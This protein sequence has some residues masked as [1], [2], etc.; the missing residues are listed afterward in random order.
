MAARVVAESQS[1]YTA[2]TSSVQDPM[3]LG[4]QEW[5][6]VCAQCHGMNGTGA[7]GPNIQSNSVLVQKPALRR[8]LFEGQNVLK[9]VS[10]YMPPVGRGWTDKQITALMSYIKS[11]VYKAPSGG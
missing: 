1:A 5:R 11:R 4:G 3:V 9:P 6:G 2:Y 8:L 7:Y 10:S